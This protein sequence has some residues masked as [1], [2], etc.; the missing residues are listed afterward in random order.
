VPDPASD[1]NKLVTL[2]EGPGPAEFGGGAAG[3]KKGSSFHDVSGL[4]L[5]GGAG[6]GVV[7]NGSSFH[8]AS[9]LGAG[10]GGAGAGG[11]G[12]TDACGGRGDE[13]GGAAL[14]NCVKLPSPDADPET[15]G[16]E[17]PLPRAGEPIGMV[18]GA[19]SPLL[20]GGAA[21]GVFPATKIRVNSPGAGS[22]GGGTGVLFTDAAGEGAGG[23]VGTARTG[24]G[25]G[26]PG[27]RCS[28]ALNIWVNAPGPVDGEWPDEGAGGAGAD[29][30]SGWVANGS[31]ANG[32]D[33]CC[34]PSAGV[35]NARKNI[36]VALSGSGCSGDP[37]RGFASL[38]FIKASYQ[39]EG[40][41]TAKIHAPLPSVKSNPAVSPL[42]QL[43][44]ERGIPAQ[45][46]RFVRL[47]H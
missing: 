7:K 37:G 29:A 8:D 10:G 28:T 45:R 2:G 11:A 5:G 1:D 18:R 24:A 30:V 36:P 38:L 27:V 3:L 14:K 19:S 20:L 15:P 39:P 26:A 46:K 42:N 23:G 6:A 22:A 33:G 32:S 40:G 44:A 4:G 35:S 31:V 12:A 16:E 17:N 9:V 34:P 47:P 21:D 43:G 25:A 13:A 41:L